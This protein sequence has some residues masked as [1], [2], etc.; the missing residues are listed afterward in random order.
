MSFSTIT[1]ICYYNGQILRT[2]I[3]VKYEGR[4]ARIVPLEV[5]LNAIL[6]N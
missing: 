3:D 2:G 4:K 6:N 1:M 5:R